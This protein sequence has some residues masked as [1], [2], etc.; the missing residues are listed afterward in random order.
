M[1]TDDIARWALAGG[2]FVDGLIRVRLTRHLAPPS[3]VWSGSG[4]RAPPLQVTPEIGEIDI[5][6]AEAVDCRANQPA[7]DG[8]DASEHHGAEPQPRPDD[9]ERQTDHKTAC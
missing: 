2:R 1:V 8:E 9:A 4:L 7:D 6:R 3:H 5:A